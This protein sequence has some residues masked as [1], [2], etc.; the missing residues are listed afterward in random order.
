MSPEDFDDTTVPDVPAVLRFDCEHGLATSPTD[1]YSDDELY[2]I[3]RKHREE[4]ATFVFARDLPDD[5][6]D[7]DPP[8]PAA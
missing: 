5:L 7:L 8:T 3:E 6:S 2:A 1:R 4:V